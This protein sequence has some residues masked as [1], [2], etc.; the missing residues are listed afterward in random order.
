MDSLKLYFQ[1]PTNYKSA[2]D[3]W[4]SLS[5]SEKNNLFDELLIECLKESEKHQILIKSDHLNQNFK[6]FTLPVDIPKCIDPPTLALLFQ[7]LVHL[8]D[9]CERVE[10]N[11]NYSYFIESLSDYL[12]IA[13]T[14]SDQTHYTIQTPSTTYTTNLI[15][16]DIIPIFSVLRICC[17]EL[18]DQFAQASQTLATIISHPEVSI[19]MKYSF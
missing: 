1:Q 3:T 14:P 17:E 10:D 11:T 6:F 8:I 7:P 13:L 19:G 2:R 15:C 4:N 5:I 9:F 16:V 12:L 18:A